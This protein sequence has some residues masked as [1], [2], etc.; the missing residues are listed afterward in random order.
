MSILRI[1]LKPTVTTGYDWYRFLDH[2]Q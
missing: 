2:T 1:A